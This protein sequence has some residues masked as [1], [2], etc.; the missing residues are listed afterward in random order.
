MNANVKFVLDLIIGFLPSGIVMA[1]A[2][3]RGSL[4]MALNTNAVQRLSAAIE[5]TVASQGL[6]ARVR[7][8]EA[9]K[10]ARDAVTAAMRAAQPVPMPPATVT[11]DG[12]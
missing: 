8:L 7:Q 2:L 3:W 11:H 9:D 4:K 5:G 10:T 12:S 1:V 6:D